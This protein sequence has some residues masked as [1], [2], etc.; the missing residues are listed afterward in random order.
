MV[1]FL[2]KKNTRNAHKNV[3]NKL[4]NLRISF[5]NIPKKFNTGF[6]KRVNY[7]CNNIPHMETIPIGGKQV[8]L[9]RVSTLEIH[10]YYECN[11]FI[12]LVLPYTKSNFAPKWSLD[13]NDLFVYFAA[14]SNRNVNFPIRLFSHNMSKASLLMREQLQL[15]ELFGMYKY[16]SIKFK[17][18]YFLSHKPNITSNKNIT[19]CYNVR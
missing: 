15:M 12:G 6:N 3:R 8:V 9:G 16:R 7:A 19:R 10:N 13:I 18:I 5:N 1:D 2:G 17:G 14:T 11:K 4:A